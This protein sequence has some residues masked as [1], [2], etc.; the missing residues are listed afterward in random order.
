MM[1]WAESI[2]NSILKRNHKFYG[3]P[4]AKSNKD[5]YFSGMKIRHIIIILVMLLCSARLQAQT[6]Y[7]TPYG[8]K[9]HTADCRSVK[10]V[11]QAIEA[12]D[13]PASGLEACK[14]C[15]PVLTAGK[16]GGT[17]KPAGEA[18]NTV[19]CKGITKAGTRCK[20]NT[21]IANGYCHQHQP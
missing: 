9:Y 14:I 4:L 16:S 5:D 13:I 20:H 11:S 3:I 8:Q 17:K 15:R 12:K 21:S 1:R 19:Q 10:N 2:I 6:F 7:K 18:K